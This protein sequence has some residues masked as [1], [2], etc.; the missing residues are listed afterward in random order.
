MMKR[1]LFGSFFVLGMAL[2][3]SDGSWFPLPNLAGVMIIAGFG[4]VFAE[5]VE[6]E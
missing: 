3:M 2:A 6:K 4:V 1:F 5:R